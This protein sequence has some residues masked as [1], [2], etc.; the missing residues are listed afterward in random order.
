QN[1]LILNAKCKTQKQA[2][3]LIAKKAKELGVINDESNLVNGLIKREEVSTTGMKQSFAI[4]HAMD[5]DITKPAIIAVRF[6]QGID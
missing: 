6:S 4:P 5:S 1:H 2:F 3:E